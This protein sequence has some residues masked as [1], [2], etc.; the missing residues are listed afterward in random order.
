MY[1]DKATKTKPTPVKGWEKIAMKK[2]IT[3]LVSVR[4]NIEHFAN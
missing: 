2:K 3:L 1:F 4:S